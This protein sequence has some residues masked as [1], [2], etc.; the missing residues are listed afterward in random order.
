MT[1]KHKVM[2]VYKHKQHH[3][4]YKPQ[5]HTCH[6]APNCSPDQWA[7]TEN[8]PSYC[9]YLMELQKPK[10][11]RLLAF[12]RQQ[13]CKALHSTRKPGSLLEPFG[14][15]RSPLPSPSCHSPG[16]LQSICG[17][18]P[19]DQGHSFPT[20]TSWVP[21]GESLLDAPLE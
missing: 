3:Y 20:S 8:F 14:I 7:S 10:S 9:G 18:S 2:C 16:E 6:R 15:P 5:E 4:Y 1:L 13:P 19:E 11:I 21:R 17:S 12:P